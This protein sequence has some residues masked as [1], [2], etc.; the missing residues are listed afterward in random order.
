[1]KNL[2]Y[3]FVTLCIATSIVSC[4]SNEKKAQENIKNYLMENSRDGTKITFNQFSKLYILLPKNESKTPTPDTS[5]NDFG[6]VFSL[7]SSGLALS[8]GGCTS[9]IMQRIIDNDKKFNEWNTGGD[10]FVMICFFTG[11]DKFLNEYELGVCARLDSALNVT[12]LYKV[13]NNAE[14]KEM[15]NQ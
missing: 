15:I 9:K 8:L 1:M 6:E 10:E 5:G 14:I 2:V 12:R 13:K 7:Y 4:N 3:L 11:K